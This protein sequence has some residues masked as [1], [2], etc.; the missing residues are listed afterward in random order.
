M[1][2]T[3]ATGAPTWRTAREAV[4]VCLLRSTLRRTVRIALVV[5]TVLSLVNQSNRI[6]GG[7]MTAM[8]WAKVALNYVVPFCVSS[9]GFLSA[10]RRERS[11]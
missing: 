10:T 7:T 9:V 6:F 11:T 8:V 4:R 1:A 3:G 5:G 2:T